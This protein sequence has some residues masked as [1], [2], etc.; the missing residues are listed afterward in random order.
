M[1]NLVAFLGGMAT[2]GFLLAGLFFFR[3]WK[4]TKDSLF[5][6]FGI[7]FWLLAANQAF[8]NVSGIAREDLS[9]VYSLR[10]LAFVMLIYGIVGKNIGQKNH[11]PRL[12]RGP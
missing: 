4:R 11:G 5:A 6:K 8:I 2:M 10:I 1:Q 7:A 12:H 3:F 9:W